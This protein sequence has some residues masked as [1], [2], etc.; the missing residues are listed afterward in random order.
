MKLREGGEYGAK[1]CAWEVFRSV[2]QVASERSYDWLKNWLGK[3]PNHISV[4]HKW[5]VLKL[6]G[7]KH[8]YMVRTWTLS[9][10]CVVSLMRQ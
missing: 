2:K 8:G 6:G 4:L 3:R 1:E 7:G 5:K 10:V 9:A